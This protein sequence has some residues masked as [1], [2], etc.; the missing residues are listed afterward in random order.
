VNVFTEESTQ[1]F[2]DERMFNL[3]KDPWIPV[4]TKSGERTIIAPADLVD[5]Y[6]EDPVIA[7][8]A[9]RPDFNGA[10]VQF[11]I[12]LV[13]TTC[14]PA[15]AGDWR[16]KFSNPPT[17]DEL[18]T[19]FERYA[20]AFNLD[21]TGA[22]FR[23]DLD[24]N[25]DELDQ[26]EREKI[27]VPIE[28]L[29]LEMPGDITKEE[30]RDF[31]VKRGTVKTICPSCSAIA[32]YTLQTHAPSGGPGYRFSIRGGSPLTTI[33][34]GRTLWETIWLNVV[35]S[36]AFNQFGNKSKQAD[37]DK[38]PWMGKTR[39]SEKDQITT[40]QDVNGAQ[41]FWGMPWR[42]RVPFEQSNEHE[43]CDLCGK[44]ASLKVSNFYRKNYGINYKGGWYHTLTP[45]L[46]GKDTENEPRPFESEVNGISYRHWLG[47]IQNNPQEKIRP[48]TVIH[49]YKERKEKLEEIGFPSTRLW[50]FGYK[51]KQRK[52]LCWNDSTMPIITVIPTI[53]QEYEFVIAQLITSADMIITKLQHCVKD[54]LFAPVKNKKS[55]V[56]GN[57]SFIES[58]FWQGTEPKFYQVLEDSKMALEKNQ[59]LDDIRVGWLNLLK[60]HAIT[61]FDHY[62]QAEQIVTVTNP[63]R[64]IDARKDLL[65]YLNLNKKLYDTLDISKSA[66]TGK[67]VISGEKKKEKHES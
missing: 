35:D 49:A 21:G 24:L 55:K 51:M 64:I 16:K 45:Y 2:R 14:P 38:F 12:G 43:L 23:Q 57:F 10:L 1:I 67:P 15:H 30:N 40:F 22:R 18:N 27:E 13:Q 47:L 36:D 6:A 41:M 37:S 44:T 61:L 63:R 56:S 11:L 52:A 65:R 28:E 7:L 66:R 62:S 3:I 26:K 20:H 42:I 60:K 32:L 19:A 4:T 9:A 25:I 39:T 50:A 34:L 46:E 33:V 54:A 59:N 17:R 29:I 48:A 8:D 31:F 58:R 5:R 53:A